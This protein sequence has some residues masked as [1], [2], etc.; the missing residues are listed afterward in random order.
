MQ[1]LYLN[2]YNLLLDDFYQDHLL[3]GSKG[4]KIERN[5]YQANLLNNLLS[6][7]SIKIV[8]ELGC[9][10]GLTA[11]LLSDHIKYDKAYLFD[12]GYDTYKEYW[13]SYIP[14][15]YPLRKINNHKIK[16]D[17]VYSF[18]CCGTCN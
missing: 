2:S 5:K 7:L 17:L 4:I 15:S 9:G 18:F 8:C 13:K 16:C 11:K 14:K 1:D 6:N 3:F 10:K 12:P